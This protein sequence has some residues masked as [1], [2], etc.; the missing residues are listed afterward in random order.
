[1]FKFCKIKNI[2]LNK[3]FIFIKSQVS[4]FSRYGGKY[5]NKFENSSTKAKK[6]KIIDV[7]NTNEPKLDKSMLNINIPQSNFNERLNTKDN[8]TKFLTKLTQEFYLDQLKDKNRKLWVTHDGPSFANG[9]PHLG[10][11]YN[12]VIKDSLNRLKIMQG[13][14]VHYNIG[15]DCYGVNIEDQVVALN[16]VKKWQI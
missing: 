12:K 15:F 7:T 13:Y 14:K 1:M 6:E 5:D 3:N 9:K 2:S 4:L 11:L 8:E 16:K 10:L